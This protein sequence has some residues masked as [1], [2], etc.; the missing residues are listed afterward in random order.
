MSFDFPMLSASLFIT[1]DNLR[2]LELPAAMKEEFPEAVAFIRVVAPLASKVL[3]DNLDRLRVDISYNRYD[4]AFSYLSFNLYDG[5]T[6]HGGGEMY[7]GQAFR[8][9]YGHTFTQTQVEAFH[10]IGEAVMEHVCHSTFPPLL[11]SFFG[12][13][14][15]CCMLSPE[16]VAAVVAKVRAAQAVIPG[17]LALS[18]MTVSQMKTVNPDA[19]A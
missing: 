17:V 7:E 10:G 15:C 13:D 16:Q 3:G 8:P 1:R 18:E 12:E 6:R 19:F 2:I 11:I 4:A 9:D 14:H 5:E